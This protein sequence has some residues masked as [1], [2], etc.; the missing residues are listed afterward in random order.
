MGVGLVVSQSPVDRFGHGLRIAKH[1]VVPEPQDA[2]PGAL[3]E[4]SARGVNVLRVLPAVDL[5]R[6]HC[7]QA[8]KVDDVISEWVLS[9]KLE[10]V[11]VLTLKRTP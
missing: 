7:F 2:K 9:A 6:Q 1:V 3:K 8:H 4:P 5:H 11:E 10:T